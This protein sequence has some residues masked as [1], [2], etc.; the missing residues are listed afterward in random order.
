MAMGHER[1]ELEAK[2]QVRWIVIWGLCLALE[3]GSDFSIWQ[4]FFRGRSALTLIHPSP[5][6]VP[7]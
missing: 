6:L 4:W 5:P 7:M 1:E 2:L 3:M